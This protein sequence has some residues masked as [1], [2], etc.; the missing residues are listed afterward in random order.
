MNKLKQDII[1]EMEELKEMLIWK[2]SYGLFIK[3]N[4][5]FKKV[6]KLCEEEIRFK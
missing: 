3:M 4:N 1:E 6:E 5:L 2:L